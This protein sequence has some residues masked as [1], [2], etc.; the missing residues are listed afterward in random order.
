MDV[1]LSMRLSVCLFFSLS[2]IPLLLPADLHGSLALSPSLSCACLLLPIPTY[3][4][5][6]LHE[7]LPDCSVCSC[8]SFNCF[9]ATGGLVSLRMSL[10]T[11]IPLTNGPEKSNDSNE[12]KSSAEKKEPISSCPSTAATAAVVAAG[13]AFSRADLTFAGWGRQR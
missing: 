1:S 8:L 4:I 6:C 9:F 11:S 2:H 5:L 7:I 3:R 13:V 12:L 10:R